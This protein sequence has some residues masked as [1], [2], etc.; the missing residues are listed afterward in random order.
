[1]LQVDSL[2][3]P[4]MQQQQ[5]RQL[6]QAMSRPGLTC[7]VFTQWHSAASK[8]TAVLTVLATLTD[9]QVSVYDA[10]DL[11]QKKDWPM[12]QTNQASESEADFIV[13]KGVTCSISHP[14][15]GDLANPEQSATVILAV[16][17][18]TEG[19][20][21]LKLTGP[22]IKEKQIVNITGLDHD[23]LNKRQQW[24]GAFPLGVDLIICD[25]LHS[26][27]IPRTTLVEII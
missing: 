27:S 4:Q 16:D 12:L 23:W 1:M 25:Q 19:T 26:I 8:E 18:V 10:D 3:L 9:N 22:G 11:I 20:L 7:Q 21:S 6:V 24:C 2:W 5:Y 13:A 17:S 14:K 15:L